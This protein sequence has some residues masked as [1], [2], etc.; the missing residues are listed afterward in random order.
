L[1]DVGKIIP[2]IPP[3]DQWATSEMIH[4]RITIMARRLNTRVCIFLLRCSELGAVRVLDLP[5]MKLLQ[6]A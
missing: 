3:D 4:E 5:D 6:F 2:A 1:E